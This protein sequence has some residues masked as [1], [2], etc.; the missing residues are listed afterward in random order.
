MLEVLGSSRVEELFSDIPDDIRSTASLNLSPG[1]AEYRVEQELFRLS[2]MN[3]EGKTCFLGC[4]AYDHVIPAVVAA[5]ASRGEYLTSYTPY[6]PEISQG[7]LQTIFEYQTMIAELTG[8]EVSNASLY[9][10][11]TAAAEAAVMALNSSPKADTILYSEGLHPSVKQVLGTFFYDQPVRLEEL[12]GRDGLVDLE[13]LASRLDASVAGVLVQSPNIYGLIEPVRDISTLAHGAGALSLV[14]ANPLSL[15]LLKPPGELGA[16][17]AVGDSQ[18][19]G[20]PLN[21][22]G[23]SAGYI[24]A[25]KPLLRKLPGR[26]VGETVDTRGQRAYVLTLQ[27]REQH[28]KRQRA[29][30]NICSNQALAAVM[31]TIYLAVVGPEGLREAA[32][33]S[34]AKA[35]Y[36][37]RKLKEVLGAGI[38][39]GDNF[40]NEFTLE[41][42]FPAED[43]VR[44]MGGRH[45]LA[46]VDLEKLR[47]GTPGRF[48][49]V[50]VTEKR[51]LEELDG[52]IA[53][54]EAF[55]RQRE[56]KRG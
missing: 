27:A 32:T 52:Y 20:L 45:I 29:T 49:T 31:N 28:I 23:P 7:V 8:L 15:G 55:M 22:G 14:S 30:S 53:E 39:G 11:A 9:D 13:A 50:A 42:S 19:L 26:I 10:G 38:V 6:Q 3:Q 41:L 12:P 16:D 47:T 25:T 37:A 48:L 17:I 40:F 34:S 56:A 44:F 21:Y 24:A 2:E 1:L 54:A 51:T 35:R 36:L 33:Q 4:G 43:I 5:L 18:P 46:G